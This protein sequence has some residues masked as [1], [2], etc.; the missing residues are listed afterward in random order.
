MVKK[1]KLIPRKFLSSDERIVFESRPSAWLYMKSAVMAFIVFLAALVIFA[2]EWIPDA[3]EIPYLSDQ[4]TAS[5]GDYVQWA[6]A[7]LAGLAFLYF[8]AR[9][10]RWSSTVYAATDER[11]ITQKGILNKTYEDIP[12]TMITN[13][14]MAQSLGKRA[15][16]YGT[17][18][19]STSGLGVKKSDMVWEAVPSPMTV[20][21]KLQEV[22]DIRTKPKS[23]DQ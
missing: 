9:W 20:R 18:V 16:G 7:A 10:L 8:V 17:I 15:L 23:K 21:R 3:P 1:A 4:L 22:M 6:F 5:Y 12:V 13:I 11:I 2:W 14:D 19:F